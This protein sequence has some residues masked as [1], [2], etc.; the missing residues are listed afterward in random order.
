MVKIITVIETLLSSSWIRPCQQIRHF[1]NKDVN[2]SFTEQHTAL[3]QFIKAIQPPAAVS[4]SSGWLDLYIIGLQVSW[5]LLAF[6]LKSCAVQQ[7]A[8]QFPHQL[9]H[10]WVYKCHTSHCLSNK[11]INTGLITV[12][13]IRRWT[14]LSCYVCLRG[15][16]LE[17]RKI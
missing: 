12:L 1:Q 11:K 8:L 10:L 9:T 16:K 7:R 4:S 17:W 2:F 14:L 15:A 3:I 13:K 6:I 5:T